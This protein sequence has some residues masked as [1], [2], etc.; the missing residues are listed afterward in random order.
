MFHLMMTRNECEV[1]LKLIPGLVRGI[2]GQSED[3]TL[4]KM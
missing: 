1:D 2:N 3:N 4:R